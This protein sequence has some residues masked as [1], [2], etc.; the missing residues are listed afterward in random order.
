MITLI[1]A[2]I[3]ST[4]RNMAVALT[5]VSLTLFLGAVVVIVG[6]RTVIAP[7]I[8]GE[9][10]PAKLP[11]YLALLTYGAVFI[12][13]G[14]NLNVFT[15]Q[16][17][18]RDKKK[19]VLESVLATPVPVR[20][21]WFARSLSV[22]LPGMLIGT[23]AGIVSLLIWNGQ[24]TAHGMEVTLTPV[25]IVVAFAIVQVLYFALSLLVHLVGLAAN[26]VTGNVIAQI[27]LQAIVASMVNL[28]IHGIVVPDSW[29]FVLIHVAAAAAAGIATV[30]ALRMLTK[31]R[32]VLSA[33][34]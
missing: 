29:L 22:F 11:G 21:V 4:Y 20:R 31:E 24:L 3:R 18:I 17:L 10:D 25:G 12:A 7:A 2:G 8:A 5:W 9:L 30:A 15:A 16:P 33:R 23:A 13:T 14:L 28:G 34:T 26:A 1:S 6:L 32:I 19:H 27:S